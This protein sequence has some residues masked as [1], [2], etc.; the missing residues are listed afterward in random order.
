VYAFQNADSITTE[1]LD[2]KYLEIYRDYGLITDISYDLNYCKE[3]DWYV[4]DNQIYTQPF[5]M[6]DYALAGIT[7][8]NVFGEYLDDP[9]TGLALFDSLYTNDDYYED[10]YTMMDS[11]GID[12][13]SDEYL[14]DAYNTLQNYLSTKMALLSQST[15]ATIGDINLDGNVDAMDL[16]LLKKYLLG[17]DI[18]NEG[19]E[20]SN[21]DMNQDGTLN[22]LD[23]LTLKKTLLNI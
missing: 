5:Y 1:D 13:Y 18:S 16:T 17:V 19:V 12:I 23:L 4:Y 11:L 20:I 3:Y 15:T 6:V 8:L 21:G 14:E 7:A 22:V 2:E 10:Y 9:T